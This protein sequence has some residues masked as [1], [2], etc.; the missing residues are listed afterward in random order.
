MREICL[1]LANRIVQLKT[2]FVCYVCIVCKQSWK[3]LTTRE[4]AE[5]SEDRQHIQHAQDVIQ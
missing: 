4:E 3:F 2:K 5:T 1:G